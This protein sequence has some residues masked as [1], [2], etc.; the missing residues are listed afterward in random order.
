MIE[1]NIPKF[2]V[3][4][5]IQIYAGNPMIQHQEV[6]KILD[7]SEKKLRKLRRESEFHQKVYDY[8]MV[9]FE[10]DVVAVLKS[11]VRE[12][13]AGNTTAG[14]IV[15]EHSGKLAKNININFPS[16]YDQWLTKRFGKQIE[17]AEIVVDELAVSNDTSKQRSKPTTSPDWNER[18][19]E[20][21]KWKKRATAVNIKPLPSRRP[22]KRQ[23]QEWEESVIQAEKKQLYTNAE[24]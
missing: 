23:R 17:D 5:A 6:A 18:R 19:R 16:P 22:T 12:A 3:D 24:S 20:L 8:Y 1:S 13:V 14:R 10:T 4:K 15:L 7:I 21:H 11:M 9:T 2:V